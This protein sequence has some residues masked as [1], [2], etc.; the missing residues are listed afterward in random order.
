MSTKRTVSVLK[1]GLLVAAAV[2]VAAMLA[3]S[4]SGAAGD[5]IL[6]TVT[7]GNG[8]SG[9][10]SSDFTLTESAT[11]GTYAWTSTLAEGDGIWQG[12]VCLARIKSL[13]CD[14]DSDPSVRLRFSVTA[15]GEDT[16]FLIP[17]PVVTLSSPLT[18]PLGVASAQI[19][20][21]AASTTAQATGLFS[22]GNA[23]HAIYNGPTVWASLIDSVTAQPN[24]S[25]TNTGK[26]PA[27]PALNELIPAT[28]SSIQAAYNFKV[29]AGDDASGTSAFTVMPEPATLGLVGLGLA[30]FARRRS[31]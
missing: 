23:Y 8:T 19:G 2:M 27:D 10:V 28:L 13:G 1:G 24:H 31:R 7:A 18:N 11:L 25:E 21:S 20:V 22:D 30:L 15:G 6:V 4:P 16:T 3:V 17:S 9:E 29:T 14:I 12:P 5:T 26:Y